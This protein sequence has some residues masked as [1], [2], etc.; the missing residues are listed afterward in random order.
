MT[1]R[2][3][4]TDAPEV[5]EAPRRIAW[6]VR[7][8]ESYGV[9]S[10]VVSLVTAMIRRGHHAHI[11]GLT[12]DALGRECEAIGA[13]AHTL[14]LEA[15][16][17]LAGPWH[18]KLRNLLALRRYVRR[19]APRI[20]AALEDACIDVVHVL[21]P[22]T[23]G[24][25]A[26][27]ADRLGARCVWEMPNVIGATWPACLSRWFY[28]WHC[29]RG[30][31]IVLANSA[32]TAGT[33]GHA[34]ARPHVVHLGVD[35]QRFDPARITPVTRRELGIPDHA[36]LLG[37]VARI[38]PSKGQDRVLAAM[39]ELLRITPERNDMHL[40]LLGGPTDSDYTESLRDLAARNQAQHRLHLLGEVP[41]PQRYYAAM[42]VAINATVGAE[43]F[44]ISV[45]E[46]MMMGRPVAVHALGGPAE[47]VVHGLTG[48][49]ARDPSVA[50][51][52]RTLR[53]VLADREH[54][55]TMGQ[56]ARRQALAYFTLDAQAERYLAALDEASD[57]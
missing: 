36:A 11:V 24:L 54:W 14:D 42:D 25:G 45:I 52:T 7:G 40:L 20:A 17:S 13:E 46:A 6:I 9:R 3:A 30:N 56:A 28:Q 31:V 41:D 10:A 26:G 22:N 8:D 29:R 49:H 12:S 43:A 39:I 53:R 16:S 37:I 5:P 44:G 57:R 27:V 32:Y 21:W 34:R 48:W 1:R 23:V 33:L 55:P 51:W 35:G 19:A 4:D 50:T 2:Y 47:T 18:R 15:P 38:D